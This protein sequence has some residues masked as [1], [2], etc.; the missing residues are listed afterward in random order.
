MLNNLLDKG[1]PPVYVKWLKGFLENRQAKVRFGGKLSFSQCMRQGV[2]QG[3]VLS[4][5]LFILYINNLAEILPAETVNAIY[6]DDVTILAKHKSA[7]EANRLAQQ[8][9]DV[10]AA[11]CKE[12]KLSLNVGKCEAAFF[13]MSRKLKDYDPAIVISG[14]VIKKVLN[15]RLLG[16][17]LD[18]TL[19]FGAHISKILAG[20]KG[21]MKMLNAISGSDWGWQKQVL[22]RV[23]LGHFKSTFDYAAPAWQPWISVSNVKKIERVQNTALRTITRQAKSTP[24]DC[25]RLESEIRSFESSVKTVAQ[26]AREK[27]L[28]MEEDHPKRT[29]L[30]PEV[31]RRLPR[32]TCCRSVA[33]RATR[34]PVLD[35]RR[36][37]S[38]FQVAPWQ[39]DL[40]GTTVLPLL[41]GIKDKH[42]DPEVIKRAAAAQIR[43]LGADLVIYT[44]GSASEGNKDG[45]AAA[46][47]TR[48]DPTLPVVLDTKMKR[49]AAVTSSFD[50]EDR[51]MNIAIDYLTTSNIGMNADK[52]A[53]VTDSQSLCAAL[54]GI[55]PELEL[56][57]FRLRCLNRPLTIQW[58][59]G[60]AGVPGNELA[61][62]AA[63]KAADL[64][65]EGPA[66]I[67]W[68]AI[69]ASIKLAARDHPTHERTKKV[70]AAYSREKEKRIKSREDQTLLA[71]LRSGHTILFAGY[72]KR[73]GLDDDGQCPLCPEELN[74]RPEQDLEHWM[75]CAGT[76]AKRQALFGNN[77]MGDLGVLTSHPTETL[78]LARG[79]LLGA[80][81]GHPL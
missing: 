65:S 15:P 80:D 53:I 34:D 9:V 4:P 58:V 24:I 26:L 35:N 3:S 25:L 68:K 41:P 75:T 73:I 66:S 79:T 12:W 20:A 5:L 70:Y 44:D 32:R 59:P 54:L 40:G 62:E 38:F 6:A 22:R 27:A 30:G 52:I 49:G 76:A 48:G 8:S 69:A 61:D 67:S 7:D 28:R 81:P 78:A 46:V 21:K 14:K 63:K 57:R 42:T 43:S 23:Y 16:V 10:V 1:I 39:Q 45:G 50:E 71:K 11:W 64:F 13:S 55:D 19:T 60:H 51:A 56:L 37:M 74:P 29:V 2:P 17:L 31:A 18:R 77:G 47:V 33:L 36:P 72:R